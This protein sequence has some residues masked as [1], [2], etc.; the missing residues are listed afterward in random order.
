M[1]ALKRLYKVT[2]LRVLCLA[3]RNDSNVVVRALGSQVRPISEALAI[4]RLL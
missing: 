2:G 1:A 3:T 4:S